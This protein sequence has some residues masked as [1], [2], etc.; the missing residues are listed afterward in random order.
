MKYHKTLREEANS[1]FKRSKKYIYGS[2]TKNAE[3]LWTEGYYYGAYNNQLKDPKK[4]EIVKV[5]SEKYDSPTQIEAFI[6]GA[7]WAKKKYKESIQ[8]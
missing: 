7:E 3:Y 5:A 2:N 4:K 8:L 1:T 6:L